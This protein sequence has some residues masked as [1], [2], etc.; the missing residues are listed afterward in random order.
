MEIS[1]EPSKTYA[2]TTSG[3]CTVT[4]ADGL[5]L[6]TASSGSQAFFVATT[7]TVT[8]SDDGAKVSRAT[9][10]YALAVAGLLG[11]GDKLPAGYTR[12]E[13]LES[14][15][16][17]HINTGLKATGSLKISLEVEPMLLQAASGNTNYVFGS[18]YTEK[19]NIVFSMAYSGAWGKAPVYLYGTQKVRL[20]TDTVKS[21]ARNKFVFD[22]NSVY[23]EGTLLELYNPGSQSKASLEKE[24]FTSSKTML[25]FGSFHNNGN[26]NRYKEARVYSFEINDNA[27]KA[28]LLNYVPALDPSG[29]PCMFDLVTR[30]PFKNAGSGQFV[31]GM[32]LSQV[33]GLRLPAGGGKLTLSL[34]HEASIDRLAQA[35]LERARA[36]GWELTLQYAEAEVPAGYRRLEY[37]E[38]TGE[39]YIDTGVK[40][41]NESEVGCELLIT[42]ARPDGNSQAFFG[43]FSSP[44]FRAYST[45]EKTL[46]IN[47]GENKNDLIA[48]FDNFEVD[49]KCK[50][51]VTNSKTYL[52]ERQSMPYEL[53][54]FE[55]SDAC[56]VFSANTLGYTYWS[57]AR[58]Y[59]FS[60]SRAGE[61]QVDYVPCIAPDGKLGMYNRVDGTMKENAGSG[62]FIAG[63]ATVDDVRKL[64]LPETGGELT[65]SVPADTPDSAVEQLRKNNPTWQ[66]AIQIRTDNE[67]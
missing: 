47:A 21:N 6:C 62:A 53:V 52:N 45:S 49:E 42:Q 23:R 4:D 27:A 24:E 64:W 30:T 55:T 43:V 67:N 56:H 34:P 22:E 61:M 3:S 44:T 57:Y 60:V 2:V 54:P 18:E 33:R 20:S 35:A 12:L 38:S 15:G 31:A 9:F 11:G 51:R 50:L 58:I 37:L 19:G 66:I 32:T 26:L 13:F 40:L 16:T 5:E 1:V 63:L 25:L 29:T 65:V 7:P 59:S 28:S 10:N 48:R 41:S 39:Q 14:T 36:N 46:A 17:Q 8:V